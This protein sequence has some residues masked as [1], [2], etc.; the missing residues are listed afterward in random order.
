VLG[1]SEENENFGACR[2]YRI[3]IN[4]LDA[5]V[6]RPEKS[7]H[8]PELI[9]IISAVSLRRTLHLDDGDRVEVELA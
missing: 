5:A 3:L 8:P 9:E 7:S 2:C 1:F 4:S 6:I